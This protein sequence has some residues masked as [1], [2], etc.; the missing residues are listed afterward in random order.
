MRMVD[1]FTAALE[2]LERSSHLPERYSEPFLQF[3]P[4]SGASVSTLGEVLGSETISATDGRAARLDEVQFDLGE[5]PCWDAM[6]SAA[7]IAETALRST[8]RTRWPAFVAAVQ[9]EAVSSMF[10]F[11][12]VVGPLKLGAIDLYSVDPVSLD[13]DDS[14]RA[15]ALAAIIGRH[16][17][18]EAL[19]SSDRTEIDA[20]PRS[21]RT[22]HQATGV[23]LAQLG[24]SPEDALLMIQGH[25]FAANR[26]MMDVA[27]EIVE[28][29]LAFR[30][31][32]GRIEVVT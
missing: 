17:L 25:A 11:P 12:L 1:D 27:T 2:A 28:G 14:Q 4:V 15:S 16:V 21:R 6:R 29:R 24:M 30:R 10:A 7:P 13:A 22:I 18:R 32:S 8:G 19:A 31:R 9:D 5:G 26:S 23:V 3:L 20:N